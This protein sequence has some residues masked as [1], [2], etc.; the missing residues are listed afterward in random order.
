MKNAPVIRRREAAVYELL[1]EGVRPQ[2][3]ATKH[4]EP[5]IYRILRQLEQKQFVTRGNRGDYRPLVSQYEIVEEPVRA[6]SIGPRREKTSIEPYPHISL[7]GSERAYLVENREQ[8]RS[9][10]A[11]HLKKPRYV[12]CREL[13]SMGIA[14]N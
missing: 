2:V 9:K 5:S 4:G 11:K 14:D 7:T 8:N 12:I 6:E 10:I 3:I 1:K 13:I